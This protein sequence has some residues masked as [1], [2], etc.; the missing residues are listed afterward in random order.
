[1]LIARFKLAKGQGLVEYALILV[2]V[3]VVV[4]IILAVTGKQIAVT[5]C[6]V[7]LNIGAK[8]PDS[9]EACR[10][11]RVSII[12][13]AGGQSVGGAIAVE[14][15]VRNNPGPQTTNME[16]KFYID[17]SLIS[18]ENASKYC[19]GGGNSSCAAPGGTPYNTSGLTNGSHVFRVVATDSV[20]NLSGE[21]SFTFIV[22]N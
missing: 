16:V 9:I 8:A 7:A 6:D 20:S 4:I 5:M 1:M 2:L 11:P 3:A 21:T 10:A 15:T 17:G 18:T 19:L 13:L 22:A 14:A 12:G